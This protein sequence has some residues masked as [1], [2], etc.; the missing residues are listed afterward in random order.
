MLQMPI[1]TRFNAE[2]QYSPQRDLPILAQTMV[3]GQAMEVHGTLA[4][5]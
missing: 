4:C 2:F 3:T 1:D 5:V